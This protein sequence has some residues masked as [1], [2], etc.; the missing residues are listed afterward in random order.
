M[1]PVKIVLKVTKSL[2]CLFLSHFTAM[3]CGLLQIRVVLHGSIW[4]YMAFYCHITVFFGKIVKYRSDLTCIVFLAVIDLNLF[5]LV[6][7]NHANKE[8]TC[9]SKINMFSCSF[10]NFTRN[11][12]N[13]KMP[14]SSSM[15]TPSPPGG[16][17]MLSPP[18]IKPL[19]V[20]STPGSFQVC[21]FVGSKSAVYRESKKAGK[22]V[23]KVTQFCAMASLR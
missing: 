3:C 1:F 13:F 15:R 16:T 2:L 8:T 4:S 20:S 6:Q 17:G 18:S 11:R 12:P 21:S 22:A 23:S 14:R 5:D 7:R 9:K 10:Q 19:G